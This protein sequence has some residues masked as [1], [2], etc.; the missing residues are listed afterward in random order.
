MNDESKTTILTLPIRGMVCATCVFHVEEAL[1]GVGGVSVANVNLATEKATVEMASDEINIGQIKYAVEDAGYGIGLAK[2]TYAVSGMTCATCVAH[3]EEALLETRGVLSA[4]VNLA[5]EKATVEFVPGVAG[6]REMREMVQDAG[7]DLIMLESQET[8][9]QDALERANEMR[10]LVRK[11]VFSLSTAAII[12]GMMF[13][14]LGGDR[15]AFWTNFGFLA[16]ATPVQF[17]AG[18]QFYVGAWGALKHRTSNMNTLIVVGTSVAYFYSLAA[19]VFYNTAFFAQAHT[20]HVHSLFDHST[21]TYFDTSSAIIGLILMGRYLEARAKSRASRAIKELM[22]LQ[23]KTARVVRDGQ[24]ADVPVEEVSPGDLVIVRPG[25]KVPVDGSVVEG[26]SSVDES[27][28]TGESIPVEKSPGQQVFGATMNTT[29]SF[30]FT[31]TNTGKDTA[32]AQIVK[33]VEEAQ[34]SKAPIQR[35]ADEISSYFV[36]A[37]IAMAAIVFVAWYFLGPYP[38][39]VYAVLTTVSVLIIACPCAMGLA[40]PT[41]I[42]VGMGKGAEGGILIRSAEALERAHKIDSVVLDK[43]GTLTTGKPS[44]TDIVSIKMEQDTLLRLAASAERGSEHP[45]GQAIVDEAKNRG[46]ALEEVS[47]FNAMPGHGIEAQVNGTGVLLGTKVLM[48]QRGLELNGLEE[49]GAQLAGQGKT[50]MYL[51]ADGVVEGII[52]VAD[53]LRPESAEAVRILKGLGVEVLMLT[54]DNSRTAIAIAGELGIE[55]VLS[56]VLPED[57]VNQIKALQG[58]GKVV[59]MVGDGINDAP[60]LAQADIGIAIG[61]GTDVAMEAADITLMRGDVRGVAKAIHLSKAT[62]RTVKQN[63]FWAFAYNVALIPIAA[64]VLYP[65]FSSGG[66]TPDVLRPIL[67]DFG[68]L[69]PILAAL[70]MAISSVSVVTNSLRLRGFKARV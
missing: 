57:K 48:A 27:M 46:L 23:A 25:E 50:P 56:E 68:F 1:K 41:A 14:S 36:P 34:G 70:A 35:L 51:A 9:D 10:T 59:A 22:G 67:G 30:T 24:E 16:L 17:W 20:F 37:V 58:D 66:G 39:I 62:M 12:M 7:Y 53:T 69:N 3:A 29:G 64:G 5:S 60:A 8:V 43:T 18:K 13:T 40:T 21:G 63:L 11:F 4:N 31:A 32:L 38:A 55:R 2:K 44:V 47:R 42:M 33:L 52:A 28:L 6:F 49:R 15:L 61:T 19:T 26:F 54:G 65:L 45:L